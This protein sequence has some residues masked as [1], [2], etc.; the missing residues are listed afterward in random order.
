V[1]I[2]RIW[3]ALSIL[4]LLFCAFGGIVIFFYEGLPK[5]G[6]FLLFVLLVIS[7]PITGFLIA[8]LLCWIIR[9]FADED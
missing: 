3:A 9:G 6:D 4:W 7:L 2:M 5:P 8:K 1:G